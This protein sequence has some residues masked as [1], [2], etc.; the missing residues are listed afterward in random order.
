M[1][2]E[3]CLDSRLGTKSEPQDWAKWKVLGGF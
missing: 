1:Y 2:S 3:I